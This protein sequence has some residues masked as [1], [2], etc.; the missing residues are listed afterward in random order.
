MEEVTTKSGMSVGMVVGIAVLVAIVFGGG[1]YAYVNNKATKEKNDLQ[2]QI[3]DLQKQVATSGTTSGTT[4]AT[5]T[6]SSTTST[7]TDE[8]VNW[9]TYTNDTEGYSVKYPSNWFFVYSAEQN[10]GKTSQEKSLYISSSK[11]TPCTDY[12]APTPYSSALKINMS[13][14]SG[15]TLDSAFTDRFGSID[16]LEKTLLTIGGQPAFRG[17]VPCQKNERLG[18]DDPTWLVI[19]G[20]KLFTFDSG[21]SYIPQYD[22]IVS[23]FQF[24]K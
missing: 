15:K 20:D 11:I 8:T 23:T 14:I 16:G 21:L 9:K 4:S 3:T 7:T 10:G 17:V 13:S 19:K 12:C 2:T 6:P 18:C 24:T 5:T 1:A 22:Q